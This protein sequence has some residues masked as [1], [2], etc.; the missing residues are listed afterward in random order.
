MKPDAL[1]F[2]LFLF[3]VALSVPAAAHVLEYKAT[4]NGPSE[5]PPNASAGTGT[6]TVDFDTDT[7]MMRVVV[8]FKGLGSPTTAS[9]IHCCT[10]FA[11]TGTAGVATQLPSFPGFPLGVTLGHFDNT[12]DMS[13]ASS[14][15]PAFVTANGGVSGALNTL[16][17]GLNTG[18][19]YLNIH[20]DDF[21]AG[22]IRGFLVQVPEPQTLVLLVIGGGVAAALAK[23][24]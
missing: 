17:G 22:E 11:D 23:R 2:S 9:H 3:S 6:A 10:S 4:L 24:R 14:Y 15:N 12:F 21:P 1:L 20:T 18:R 19:A 13:Q 8:D 16:I 7:V 5:S